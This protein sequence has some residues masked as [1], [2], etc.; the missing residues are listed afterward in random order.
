MFVLRRRT[1][2][3]GAAMLAL[4]GTIPAQTRAQ[5]THEAVTRAEA[6]M[7]ADDVA[8]HIGVIAHDS[9]RGRQTPSPELEKVAEYIAGRFGEWGLQPFGDDGSFLQRYAVRMTRIDGPKAA[10]RIGLADLEIGTGVRVAF[11]NDPDPSISGDV[12]LVR[13]SAGLGVPSEPVAGKIVLM[14]QP[15]PSGALFPELSQNLPAIGPQLPA[16]IIVISDRSDAAFADGNDTFNQVIPQP[17]WEVENA[18]AFPVI[19]ARADAVRGALAEVGVDLDRAFEESSEAMTITPLPELEVEIELPRIV[20]STLTAPNVVAV[21]E[22]T[23]PELRGEYVVVS[24]HIDHIGV[25]D[26]EGDVTYNGADDNAS[27][28]AAVMEIAEAFAALEPGTARSVIFLLVSAEEH[29]LWGSSYFATHSPV[30]LSQV[31]A[32]LNLDMV[33]RNWADTI[34]AIGGEHSDLGETLQGVIDFHPELG[35]DAIP[36]PWP[37]QQLY[38]RSDHFNFAK[39]GVPILFFT[40]GV[41]EDYHEVTDEAARIDNDKVS[42][43]SRLVFHVAMAVAQIPARPEWNQESFQAIV[44]G[45]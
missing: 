15:S 10:V 4:A 32:D 9:M 22:G 19:E 18:F 12:V 1:V 29:G 14:V 34:V 30:D 37:Q 3:F 20:E 27:G 26:G 45:G 7:S 13:G 33:G 41:H 21:R 36:D 5:L 38:S 39:R 11:P 42:R 8:D 31:V 2:A 43:V 16:A 17:T 35:L 23:D 28:T 24:A 25:G 6:T 40:N 44:G